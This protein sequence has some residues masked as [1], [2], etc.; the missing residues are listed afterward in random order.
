MARS[1]AQ[2]LGG[3]SR[4]II[5]MARQLLFRTLILLSLLG[6]LLLAIAPP[7]AAAASELLQIKR[8]R[9]T[10]C[11]RLVFLEDYKT[12]AKLIGLIPCNENRPLIFAARPGE[13]YNFYRLANVV[14]KKG[15]QVNT[16][17]YGVLENYITKFDSFKEIYSCRD[18]DANAPAQSPA[19]AAQAGE[20]SRWVLDQAEMA[21]PEINSR[22]E[23]QN[24]RGNLQ[25][26]ANG[27]VVKQTCGVD[28]LCR[29]GAT[30]QQLGVQL[31]PRLSWAGV[32]GEQAS[33]WLAGL[34]SDPVAL[35][36]CPS[37][38]VIA[39]KLVAGL[40]QQGYSLDLA[41][42]GDAC[43]LLANDAQER[44]LGFQDGTPLQEI[45]GAIP[46]ENAGN[47]Y[48]LYPSGSAVRLTLACTQ[49][50]TVNLQL[51]QRDLTG[52]REYVFNR[53]SVQN[54]TRGEIDPAASPLTLSLEPRGDGVAQERKPDRSLLHPAL[55][56]AIPSPTP[57]GTPAP[58]T[59]TT[60]PP[61]PTPQPTATLTPLPPSPT[62]TPA[63]M[64][65]P[66]AGPRSDRN[67][68][69][70]LAFG[71]AALPGALWWR[72]KLSKG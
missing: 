4:R 45:P 51:V 36:A 34:L 46:V 8:N 44:R 72:R 31:G 69:C 55:V 3:L 57:I 19:S 60:S 47:Q 49:S 67:P 39:L 65:T 63:E 43:V 59:P 15:D 10:L 52:V 41:T 40:D 29:I 50:D 9:S 68:L 33:G 26:Y 70:P 38:D 23:L 11:G 2:S 12:Q 7:Q 30:V 5:R 14:I 35:E 66:A 20:C 16:L 18:C 71:M 48:L 42:I 25:A 22:Q 28:S 6:L 53:L 27:T 56:A 37:L 17:G 64:P 62:P 58:A 21:F 32:T 24:L 54:K 61:S 13:L 1:G